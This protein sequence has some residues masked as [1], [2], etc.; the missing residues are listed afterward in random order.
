MQDGQSPYYLA[1][2]MRTLVDAG[3]PEPHLRSEDVAAVAEAIRTT[4][5]RRWMNRR[6]SPSQRRW[7]PTSTTA[8]PWATPSGEQPGAPEPTSLESS[9]PE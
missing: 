1:Q 6:Q 2:A 7:S 9:T 5:T 8:K 4:A 3:Y